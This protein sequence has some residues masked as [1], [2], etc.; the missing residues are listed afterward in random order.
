MY[1]YRQLLFHHKFVTWHAINVWIWV[2]ID[3]QTVINTY[4]VYNLLLLARNSTI[5]DTVIIRPKSSSSLYRW[6]YVRERLVSRCIYTNWSSS[7]YPFILSF[8]FILQFGQYCGYSY[9][10]ARCEFLRSK[11]W[12]GFNNSSQLVIIPRALPVYVRGSFARLKFPLRNRVYQNLAVPSLLYPFGYET[13]TATNV[14][15]T[16]GVIFPKLVP[17]LIFC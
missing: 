11:W 16:F 14:S 8:S 15:L 12:I 4:F 9:I 7:M 3:R 13:D 10:E 2:W 6:A 1:Q 5:F 17:F